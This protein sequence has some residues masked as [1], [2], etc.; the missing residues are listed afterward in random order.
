MTIAQTDDFV[1]FYQTPYQFV[2]SGGVDFMAVAV[3]ILFTSLLLLD[4]PTDV[5]LQ[6]IEKTLILPHTQHYIRRSC[7]LEGN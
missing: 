4:D 5:I 6:L 7:V 1:H 3:G 2:L